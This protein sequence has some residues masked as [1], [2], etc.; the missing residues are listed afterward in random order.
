ML[1]LASDSDSAVDD[2]DDSSFCADDVVVTEIVF[3]CF[4]INAFINQH[5]ST[6]I[7]GL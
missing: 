5:N 4:E 6:L 3:D 7:G 1:I 2:E